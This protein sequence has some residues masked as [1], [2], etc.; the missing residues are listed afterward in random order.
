M[1]N[2]ES[3]SDIGT[4]ADN[5]VDCHCSGSERTTGIADR[6]SGSSTDASLIRINR[7]P[8]IPISQLL[9]FLSISLICGMFSAPGFSTV[10]DP[11]SVLFPGAKVIIYRS[12]ADCTLRASRHQDHMYSNRS[13]TMIAFLPLFLDQ[14]CPAEAK[15]SI[16]QVS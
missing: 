6:V 2:C 7:W 13:R 1:R 10:L 12:N 3:G 5:L 15:E 11:Q 9:M 14:A 16:D 8:A 4:S